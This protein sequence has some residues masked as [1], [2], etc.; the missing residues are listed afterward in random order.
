MACQGLENMYKV[1]YFHMQPVPDLLKLMN[2]I[3]SKS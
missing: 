2:V 1:L 3:G